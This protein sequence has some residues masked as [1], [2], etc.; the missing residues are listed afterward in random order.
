MLLIFVFWTIVLANDENHLIDP[1]L[2]LSEWRKAH[3]K[4][5]Q[6]EDA[7]AESES[8]EIAK[9]VIDKLTKEPFDNYQPFR[10]VY[11]KKAEIKLWKTGHKFKAIMEAQCEIVFGEKCMVRE[12]T[13]DWCVGF[14]LIKL[15]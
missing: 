12:H 11:V 6:E 3:E 13:Y 8:L 1:K 10:R 4:R 7:Q 9:N 14:D 15:E 5:K 2:K